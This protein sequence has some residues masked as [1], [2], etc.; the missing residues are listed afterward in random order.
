MTLVRVGTV[1]VHRPFPDVAEHVVKPEGVGEIVADRG[2]GDELVV[3][4]M[5]L[6]GAGI[7]LLRHP[8]VDIGEFAGLIRLVP[9]EALPTGA[10]A[11]GEFPFGFGGQSKLAFPPLLL[12]Q[13][14][15]VV[16][17][18]LPADVDHRQGGAVHGQTFIAAAVVIRFEVLELGVGD[19]ETPHPETVHADL[20]RR[21][22]VG[23]VLPIQRLPL[24]ADD[25][26]LFLLGLAHGKTAA[27]DPN[28][29]MATGLVLPDLPHLSLLRHLA[30][31]DIPRRHRRGGDGL[32]R[33]RGLHRFLLDHQRPGQ[34]V[35]ASGDLIGIFHLDVGS[36]QNRAGGGIDE[37]G[38]NGQGLAPAQH[39]AADHAGDAVNLAD[40]GGGL[41]VEQAA[42]GKLLL[43]QHLFQQHPFLEIERTG[44][45]EGADHPFGDDRPGI[46]NPEFAHDVE[47]DHR[48]RHLGVTIARRRRLYQQAEQQDSQ[49][50]NSFQH[51]FIPSER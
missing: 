15:G 33:R 40:L 28:E 41:V 39:A 3:A 11:A 18:L 6:P 4:V 25:P 7:A 35:H 19:L 16:P 31:N 44:T 49:I 50:D 14:V 2:G 22:L 34:F 20:V 42:G 38:G 1:A 5:F 37:S 45:A 13:P 36:A 51:G 12:R 10:G 27:F 21:R 26:R 9:P 29:F 48:H 23:V 17:C 47:L 30:G 24:L 8:V 46:G 32:G 43:F